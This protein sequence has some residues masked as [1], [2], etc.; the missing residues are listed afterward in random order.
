MEKTKILTEQIFKE[1]V[2]WKAVNKFVQENNIDEY[3][4]SELV[5]DGYVEMI[6]NSNVYYDWM[7]ENWKFYDDYNNHYW[8]WDF[9]NIALEVW[10]DYLLND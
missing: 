4:S 3:S 8:K 2:D 6:T 5:S 7:I 1:S 10:T 9:D